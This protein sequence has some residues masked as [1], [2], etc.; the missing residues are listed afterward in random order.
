M[1][2]KTAKE[3]LVESFRELAQV[4]PI[5]K[6]TVK[7]ICANCAYSS[8]TFYRSFHDKYDLIAW[9]YSRDIERLL[10]DVGSDY[11]AWK[12]ALKQA[13]HYYDAQKEYLSNLLRHTEG[14]DSFVRY[15]I[16]IHFGS[17]RNTV[18]KAVGAP[19]DETL[20]HYI[21][22]YVNGTVTFTCEWLLGVHTL[23]VEQLAEIYEN[24]LPEILR[25]KLTGQ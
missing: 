12:E 20:E 4:K 24:S 25:V 16:E 1:K 9:D 3:I 6:I 2:R 21:R 15:M 11:T 13:A 7:D 22:I 23:G 10:K 14:Y 17:F 18:L 8:A 5:D 19:T